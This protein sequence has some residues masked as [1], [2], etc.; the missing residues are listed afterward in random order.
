MNKLNKQTLAHKLETLVPTNKERFKADSEAIRQ[1]LIKEKPE[2]RKPLLIHSTAPKPAVFYMITIYFSL[3]QNKILD[4]L[5]T[6]G[7]NI[8]TQHFLDNENR[9]MSYYSRLYHDDILFITISRAD[10]TSDYLE[11]LIVDLVETRSYSGKSTVVIYDSQDMANFLQKLFSYFKSIESNT[12]Q[13]TSSTTKV[14]DDNTKGKAK[15]TRVK[16]GGVDFF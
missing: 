9:D 14:V 8:I 2:Y 5:I 13:L 16:N 11:S 7:Q 3:Q 10:Y 15:P 6:T 1:V 12:L 4:Y